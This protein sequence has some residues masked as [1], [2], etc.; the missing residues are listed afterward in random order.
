[1]SLVDA[2][3]ADLADIDIDDIEQE[4]GINTQFAEGVR[5][6]AEAYTLSQ[7]NR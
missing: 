5:Q 3:V 2:T 4:M 1:M 6:K 7:N